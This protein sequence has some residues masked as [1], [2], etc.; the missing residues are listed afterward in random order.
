MRR[1]ITILVVGM[2]T[3]GFLLLRGVVVTG[4]PEDSG[5]D[6]ELTRVETAL[7]ISDSSATASD[8][9]TPAG[10]DYDFFEKLANLVTLRFLLEEEPGEDPPAPEPSRTAPPPTDPVVTEAALGNAGLGPKAMPTPPSRLAAIA[11]MPP[12]AMAE[13]RLARIVAEVRDKLPVRVDRGT[14]LERVVASGETVFYYYTLGRRIDPSRKAGFVER[15]GR[16]LR[17][18]VCSEALIAEFARLGARLTYVYHD[19]GRR[20]VHRFTIDPA[21]CGEEG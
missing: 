15:Q 1:I 5:A 17:D 13:V 12:E 16:I 3:T 19:A 8:A 4:G 6:G 21:R 20:P 9:D 18:R 14:T 7:G 10:G 11:G 2:A